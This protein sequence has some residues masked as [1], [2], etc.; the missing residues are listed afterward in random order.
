MEG[1]EG[2]GKYADALE[3]EIPYEIVFLDLTIPG[4]KGGKDAVRDILALSPEAKVVAISGYSTD[5]IMAHYQEYGFSGRLTKPF[6][7]NELRTEISRI[8]SN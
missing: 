8:L 7:L 4:G 1:D 3:D 2:V 5:P 6:Q